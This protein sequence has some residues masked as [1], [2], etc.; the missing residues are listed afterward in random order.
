MK[1]ILLAL[2]LA[3]PSTLA[4]AD[5]LNLTYGPNRIAGA[6]VATSGRTSVG[7]R[8]NSLNVSAKALLKKRVF[9]SN[10]NVYLAHVLAGPNVMIEGQSAP[11]A[12]EAMSDEN[13]WALTMH[14]VRD[15]DNATLKS[16]FQDSMNANA[17]QGAPTTAAAFIRAVG[18]IGGV[19][20]GE[21]LHLVG[22]R[23]ADGTEVLTVQ[24]TS[25]G[26]VRSLQRP[27]DQG[28]LRLALAL[29]FGNGPEGD[30]DFQRMQ[31]DLLTGD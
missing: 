5:I 15:V 6:P 4:S 8:S 16:A 20:S 28:A 1:R 7:G 2:C 24:N 3:L 19:T 21:S 30:N 29:L 18:E 12:L 25:S 31:N 17:N 9:F 23:L 14:F 27:G 22:E 11:N 10:V 26:I 13:A